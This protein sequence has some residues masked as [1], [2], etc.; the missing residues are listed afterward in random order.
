MNVEEASLISQVLHHICVWLA[1][2]TLCELSL[3]LMLLLKLYVS[4]L[5]VGV[6][7]YATTTLVSFL[8]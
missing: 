7:R 5:T 8:Q 3:L 1:W 6:F 2:Q 4:V